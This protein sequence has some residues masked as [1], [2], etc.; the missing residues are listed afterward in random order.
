MTREQ[1][2]E[3]IRKQIFIKDEKN[4]LACDKAFEI[5]AELGIEPSEI[6]KVCNMLKIKIVACQL[7]CFK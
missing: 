2:E 5:A 7:G 6:G 4:C 3:K 1:I